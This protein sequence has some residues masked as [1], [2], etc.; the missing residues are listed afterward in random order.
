VLDVTTDESRVDVVAG[1][2]TPAFI[3]GK[4]SNGT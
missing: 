1:G 3:S 4:S 2:S